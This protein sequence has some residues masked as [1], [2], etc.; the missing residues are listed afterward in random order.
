ML[1]PFGVFMRRADHLRKI[2]DYRITSHAVNQ[3]VKFVKIAVYKACMCES[4][5]EV[6][7]LRVQ[8][9]W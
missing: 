6:H 4:D 3:D 2:N 8:F 9:P 5:N 1:S 7:Q